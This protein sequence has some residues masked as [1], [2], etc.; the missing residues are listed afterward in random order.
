LLFSGITPG[1]PWKIFLISKDGGTPTAITADETA[2]EAD[3]AWSPD[4]KS[5]AF[6]HGGPPV[7]A[8][9]SF[10]EVFDVQTHQI[11]RLVGSQGVFA[12]RW[13][14]DGHYIVGLSNDNQKLMLMDVKTRQWRE[15]SRSNSFGYLAWSADSRYVYFDTLFERNP[16]YQRVRVL[17]GRIETIVDMKRIRTF[18]T[19]FGGL[20]SWTGLGPGDT[21][22]F[23]RDTSSQEIYALDLQLP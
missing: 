19:Q 9:D 14:P 22:L 23:V 6:G 15:L 11:S 16:V 13:S 21:P 5:L 4:G 10:I 17:D 2:Q 1:K 3:P 18:P 8:E 7:A 12:S 20:G